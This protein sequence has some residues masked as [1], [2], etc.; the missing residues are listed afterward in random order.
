MRR[1]FAKPATES[2]HVA[3]NMTG[4]EKVLSFA[5]CPKKTREGAS[6]KPRLRASHDQ[7]QRKRGMGARTAVP[8]AQA[9]RQALIM[10]GKV[11]AYNAA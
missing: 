11:Q 10:A 1:A 7:E 2:G 3:E 8:L 4:P 5:K 6:K 9:A